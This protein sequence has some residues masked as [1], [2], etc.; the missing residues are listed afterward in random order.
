MLDK[1]DKLLSKTTF[2][3]SAVTAVVKVVEYARTLVKELK[4]KEQ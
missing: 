3:L 1:I 2:I 4:E